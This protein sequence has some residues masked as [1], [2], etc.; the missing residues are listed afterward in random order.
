[1]LLDG[2]GSTIR[3]SLTAPE[4]DEVRTGIKILESVG[5]RKSPLEVISCPTCG[6][7]GTNL[8]EI[9]EQFKIRSAGVKLTRP[10]KVAIMG[11]V[12]NGPGEAKDADFGVACGKD[13]S[14]IF[15]ENG[16]KTVKNESI[17]DE[18]LM[19]LNRY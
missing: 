3:V 11:C 17:L 9:V 10:V 5:L 16:S 7:T 12:V 2:I 6:R 8:F 1:M 13:K 19:L 18:L 15:C 14:V 4:E